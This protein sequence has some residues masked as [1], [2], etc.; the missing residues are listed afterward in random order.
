[1]MMSH[2]NM[3]QAK[4]IIYRF[5]RV[6]FGIASSPFLLNGSV[7]HHLKN[8]VVSD[9][10]F[11]TKFIEDVYVGDTTSRCSSVEKGMEFYQK[12][13]TI[14]LAGRSIYGSG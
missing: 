5:L 9:Q 13:K 11:I 12:S 2:P 7:R 1:M 8:Y 4:P 10:K 14:V 3:K 6:E